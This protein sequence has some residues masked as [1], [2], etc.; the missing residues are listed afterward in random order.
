[1]FGISAKE[2]RE[3]LRILKK[4]KK[5]ILKANYIDQITVFMAFPCVASCIKLLLICS[6]LPSFV[7]SLF[8]LLFI[9]RRREYWGP[10]V[11][12]PWRPRSGSTTKKTE[13]DNRPPRT[14]TNVFNINM[15]FSNF[16]LRSQMV[17]CRSPCRVKIRGRILS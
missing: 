16:D 3:L 12:F 14:A 5:S 4:L 11:S 13:H 15:L 7:S 6:N 2:R 9:L 17:E 8:V 1:M 10:F